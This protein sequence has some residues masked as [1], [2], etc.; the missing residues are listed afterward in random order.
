MSEEFADQEGLRDKVSARGEEAIGDLASALLDSPLFNQALSAAVGAGERAAQAQK[1]AMGAVGLPSAGELERLERRM[2]SL[3]DRM[4]AV[5]DQLDQVAHEVG[6]LR[7]Q[8]S[9][10]QPV[11]TDQESLK[12]S[13]ED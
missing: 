11:S 5:E 10:D 9:G 4:E 8:L 6:A 13:D 3:S 2:R 1:A 7:R 12:V